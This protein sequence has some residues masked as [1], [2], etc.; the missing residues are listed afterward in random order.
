MSTAKAEDEFEQWYSEYPR[1][2]AKAAARKA[3]LK[4]RKT[5][6]LESLMAGL[7]VYKKSIQGKDRQF[8]ALPATWLN[9]GRWEDELPTATQSQVPAAYGWFN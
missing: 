8:I 4:A 5:A 7:T 2:E 6:P 3:F 9:A 1:K